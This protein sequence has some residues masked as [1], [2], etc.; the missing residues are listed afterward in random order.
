MTAVEKRKKSLEAARAVQQRRAMI[1]RMLAA[2]EPEARIRPSL[3]IED[4]ALATMTAYEFCLSVWRVGREK[5]RK[6]CRRARVHEAR[7]LRDLTVRQRVALC[8]EL[9]E[10][11]DEI[12]VPDAALA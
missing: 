11:P 3:V 4:G 5:A 2:R 9:G 6:V 8:E 10:D 12:G 1:R 7:L